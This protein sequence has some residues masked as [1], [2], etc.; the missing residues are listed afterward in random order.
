ML[1]QIDTGRNVCAKFCN[2]IA[3]SAQK[4]NLLLYVGFADRVLWLFVCKSPYCKV[5]RINIF[6]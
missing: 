1:D 2:Y 5:K 4:S 6:A 3:E